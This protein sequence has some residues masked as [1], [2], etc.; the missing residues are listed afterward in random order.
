MEHEL[1]SIDLLFPSLQTLKQRTEELDFQHTM[2]LAECNAL[3]RAI[4]QNQAEWLFEPYL[5]NINS[6]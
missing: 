4:V 5:N 3:V 2:S 6:C 1:N